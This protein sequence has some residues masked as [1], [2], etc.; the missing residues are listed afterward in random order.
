MDGHTEI[1]QVFKVPQLSVQP[2][3]VPA[4]NHVNLT[5]ANVGQHPRVRGSWLATR[6]AGVIVDVFDGRQS[7]LLTQL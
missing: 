1:N 5:G 6:C 2:V 7:A 4:H 3:G